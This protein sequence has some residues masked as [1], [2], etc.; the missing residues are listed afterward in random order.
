M[1]IIF[2]LKRKKIVIFGLIE[3]FVLVK[4]ILKCVVLVFIFS[5]K[6]LY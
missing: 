2:V 1:I 3:N 6:W 5:K 4:L